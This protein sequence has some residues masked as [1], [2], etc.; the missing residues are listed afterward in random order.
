MSLFYAETAAGL[1]LAAFAGATT[2][3]TLVLI[4]RRLV[5]GDGDGAVGV[6]I[7]GAVLAIVMLGSMF[8]CFSMAYNSV[9]PTVTT[10]RY[11]TVILPEV[12]P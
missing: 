2:F 1:A 6:G 5:K 3:L 11:E 4:V 7:F 12:K 9:H 8:G 10:T